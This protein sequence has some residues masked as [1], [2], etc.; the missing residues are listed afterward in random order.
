M[1]AGCSIRLSTPPRLSAK[2]KELAALEKA[3]GLGSRTP[4]A[5]R[6]HPAKPP[7]LTLCERVLR[8][9]FESPIDDGF[10]LAVVCQPL[11]Q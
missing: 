1:I 3:P 8:M 2:G 7:H 9:R 6:D 4:W 5:H 11:A 10:D